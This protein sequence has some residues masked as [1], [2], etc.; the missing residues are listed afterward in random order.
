MGENRR[1]IFQEQHLAGLGQ[2][3][4]EMGELR[5]GQP[6]YVAGRRGIRNILYNVLWV[7]RTERTGLKITSKRAAPKPSEICKCSIETLR[8]RASSCKELS[9]NCQTLVQRR[10]LLS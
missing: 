7:Q 2:R 1:E 4:R 9:A 6:S 5:V 10:L 3:M 8:S